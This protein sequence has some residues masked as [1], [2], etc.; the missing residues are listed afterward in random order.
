MHHD[1]GPE[2]DRLQQDRRGNSIVDNQRHA[3]AMG[4]FRQCLD[5]GDVAAGIADAFAIDGAR[6]R[7]D[8]RLDIFDRIA[9][10]EAHI[11]ALLAQDMLE[12]GPGRSVEL[13]S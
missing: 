9:R 13:R 1:I 10:R 11:D 2:L 12:Q 8:Q 3:V 6:V 7:I 4:A 5:V